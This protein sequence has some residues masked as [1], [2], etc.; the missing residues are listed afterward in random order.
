MRE[1]PRAAAV[2]REPDLAVGHHE[3]RVG[4][5]D[6]QV[7]GERERHAAAGRIPFDGG[8]DRLRK[9]AQRFDELV[10][11][12]D[13]LGLRLGP[14]LA[15]PDDAVEVAAGAEVLAVAAQD[16]R[17]HGGIGLGHVQRLDARGVDLR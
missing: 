13:R 7:A 9:G 5:G 12:G 8:D 3:L 14:R 17:A 11:E 10:E 4:R 16:H 6:D 15:Q 1:V 2:G